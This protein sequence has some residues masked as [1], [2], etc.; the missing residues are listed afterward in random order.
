MSCVCVLG[1]L[2]GWRG[3]RWMSRRRSDA[4]GIVGQLAT[5]AGELSLSLLG[6]S[7]GPDSNPFEGLLMLTEC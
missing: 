7:A 3:S 6:M 4:Q 1:G 5:R 2:G